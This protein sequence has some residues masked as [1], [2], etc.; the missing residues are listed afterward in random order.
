M[1][2]E[3]DVIMVDSRNEQIKDLENIGEFYSYLLFPLEME[4]V[5][6]ERNIHYV[7]G[8]TI[9]MKAAINQ[10]VYSLLERIPKR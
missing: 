10:P 7:T 3:N 1:A 9:R 5:L 8:N 4:S 6:K 2:I